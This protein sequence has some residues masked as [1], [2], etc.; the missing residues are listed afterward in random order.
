[1]TG[2]LHASW[3]ALREYWGLKPGCFRFR[4]QLVD[5]TRSVSDDPNGYSSFIP[6][7]DGLFQLW[8]G[9]V[10]PVACRHFRERNQQVGELCL[11]N[12]ERKTSTFLIRV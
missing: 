9:T 3:D 2:T 12:K 5:I 6:M 7:G 4:F 8:T 11:S 1:M 10:L